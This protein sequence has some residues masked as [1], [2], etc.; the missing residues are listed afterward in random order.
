MTRMCA[1]ILEVNPDNLLVRDSATRQE[2]L[3][4]TNCICGFRKNDRI[5]ILY[6]GI[7]TMSI[8]PQINAVRIFKAPFN[9]CF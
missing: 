4:H 8:P 6:N 1:V 2:I 3:V 7:M 5:I 9:R